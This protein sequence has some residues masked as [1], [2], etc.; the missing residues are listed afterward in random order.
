MS[1]SV[2]LPVSV[3]VQAGAHAPL[4]SR[5]LDALARC[6]G[7]ELVVV[8]EGSDVAELVPPQ[9]LRIA[10]SER[11]GRREAL[12]LA[13]QGA[14]N[15]I[16][17]ALGPNAVP[18]PGFAEPLSAA[19]AGGAALAAPVIETPAGAAFGYRV[20]DDGALV[21]RRSA[22]GPL[23]ALALDCLAARRAFWL[24][25]LPELD[26]GA[27]FYELQVAAAAGGPLAV[28]PDARV[29]RCACGPALSVVV[30]SHDR[31]HELTG[32]VES[33]VAHGALQDGCE[34]VIVDSA[35][36]DATPVVA[37]ELAVRFGAAV[38]SVREER[39]GLS[40]ARMAGA[41][42]AQN[43]VLAYIDDDV[44][45]A[46][47][48]LEALRS[49]FADEEV[50][51]AGGPIAA[52][53]PDEE[54]ARF[55]PAAL[56]PYLS[57]LTH[58]D[59]DWSAA[60]VDC[61]GANWSIRRS[62]LEAIGGFDERWG[63][64]RGGLLPGEETAAEL[65]LSR[66]GRGRSRY[67][68]AAVVGHRIEPGRL[69]DRWLLLRAYRH[70][71]VLP[72]VHAGFAEP[73][74]AAL[75]QGAQR[76]AARLAAAC[77]LAGTLDAAGALASLLAAPLALEQRA[78]AA[79][80][81]GELVASVLLLGADRCELGALRLRLAPDDASGRV[82]LPESEA[83]PPRAAP[84]FTTVGSDPAPRLRALAIVP[85][86]NEAD[87]I[88]H[89]VADLIANGI[90]VHLLDNCSSDDT[91][92]RVS[93]F[94][95]HGLVRI[96]RF[97]DEAGYAQR[98]GREFV[99]RDQLRRFEQ[100]AAEGDYDW[101]LVCDADEFRESPWPDTTL[102]EGLALVDAAGY[103]AV[104]FE[105]FNF[106]PT[107]DSFEA[108]TD[109]RDHLTRYEPCE[110]FDRGQIKAWRR[111]QAAVDLS[112]LFGVGAMFPGRRVF[113]VPFILRHYPIRGETHGRR[114]VLR[115]R[116]PRFAAD[117]RAGGWHIQYDRFRDGSARFLWDAGSL[118]EWDGDAVRARLLGQASRSLLLASAVRGHEPE[119]VPPSAA[120][121]SRWLA[122]VGA[123]SAAEDELT[124]ALEHLRLLGAGAVADGAGDARTQ[125][126]ARLSANEQLLAG[127]VR[128]AA[129]LDELA[130]RLADACRPR[131]AAV[132]F[133]DELV[134]EPALL[135]AYGHEFGAGDPATL[136]IVTET[137]ETAELVRVVEAVGLGGDDAAE[138]VA[139]SPGD[140]RLRSAHA[141]YSQRRSTAFGSLPRVEDARALRALAGRYG[142]RRAA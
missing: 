125:A 53:W 86:Y 52:V 94:L 41:A 8:H 131:F 92:A 83:R 104:N 85:A 129:A 13:A 48:W 124:A 65:T 115:D 50:T 134:A 121:I 71:L 136:V 54:S 69:S 70:G 108:G 42:A 21:P 88:E 68:A 45:V 113:P 80:D 120:A 57:L 139:V 28:C 97:P 90:D 60:I 140:E 95:G 119:A 110:W 29:R 27:G 78:F 19:L 112:D 1:A 33:L 118:T 96:E 40:L 61:Y 17:I 12:A 43:D 56:H 35:S 91:V 114:K 79:R 24:E 135:Q 14:S 109:V 15:D 106:R 58:G 122:R 74:S 137:G 99:L 127:R 141:V 102:A 18:Q 81:L 59:A 72:H 77:P 30:C 55:A 84:A 116:L 98:N 100:I 49:A 32:C 82:E 4:L 126:L 34:I 73:P 9:A 22:A 130:G 76:A 117:E 93:R 31:A 39:L 101:Y 63:A 44:R 138:L 46:P 132:A 6:P 123:G 2:S 128:E 111:T 16:C 36:T 10:A 11:L 64:G 25:G 66:L 20:D 142:L 38:R 37:A 67:V 107:D 103:S 62:A 87:V 75:Q 47:G 51:V 133:A 3:L 89:A 5:Q 105:L 7:L 23:D 26:A